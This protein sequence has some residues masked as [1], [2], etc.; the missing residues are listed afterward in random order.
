[1]PDNLSKERLLTL[2]S[3]GAE[4]VL[5]DSKLNMAGAGA[6]AA[7]I[8]EVSEEEIVKKTFSNALDLYGIKDL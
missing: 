3:F 7:E 4:V 1:M 8:L 5:T 6:K 2:K